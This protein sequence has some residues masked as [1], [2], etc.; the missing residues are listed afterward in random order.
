KHTEPQNVLSSQ[1]ES[2]PFQAH[3]A[4]RHKVT[5][6][7]QDSDRHSR[8]RHTKNR[9]D[10]VTSTENSRIVDRSTILFRERRKVRG[11]ICGPRGQARIK[12]LTNRSTRRCAT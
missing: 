4:A 11:D 6:Q 1:T 2:D 10:R 7:I 8:D 12:T 5:T 3:T 9:T